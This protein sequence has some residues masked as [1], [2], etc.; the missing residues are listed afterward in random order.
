MIK[1]ILFASQQKKQ[2]KYCICC[3][4]YQLEAA[5]GP[6]LTPEAY[7]TDFGAS[8]ESIV[9]KMCRT[10]VKVAHKAV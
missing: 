8:Q 2:R 6:K 10:D 4:P 5:V 3:C 1:K 9:E 7:G